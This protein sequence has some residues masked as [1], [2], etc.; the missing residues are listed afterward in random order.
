[1]TLLCSIEIQFSRAYLIRMII[2]KIATRRAYHQQ[3]HWQCHCRMLYSCT[4]IHECI[5]HRNQDTGAT[6][7]PNNVQSFAKMFNLYAKLL[8]NRKQYSNSIICDLCCLSLY[9]YCLYHANKLHYR[10]TW[11]LYT[12]L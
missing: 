1:M 10:A 2:M 6:E 8:L 9:A 12:L 7:K 3:W 5:Q 4:Q 11:H